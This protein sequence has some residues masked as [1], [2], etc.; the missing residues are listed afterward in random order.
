MKCIFEPKDSVQSSNNFRLDNNL[1][2]IPLSKDWHV[3]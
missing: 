2:A 1:K 3:L